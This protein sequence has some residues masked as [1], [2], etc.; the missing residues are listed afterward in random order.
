VVRSRASSATFALAGTD[1]TNP[2]CF[3]GFS[4]H[5]EW[6]LLV[7]ECKFT[8]MEATQCTTRNPAKFL[9]KDLGTL[10][11]GKIDLARGGWDNIGSSLC[12]L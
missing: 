10:E 12:Q 4:L 1:V 6:A 8:P 2:Y 11:Q 9:G 3:P 7:N 5:D